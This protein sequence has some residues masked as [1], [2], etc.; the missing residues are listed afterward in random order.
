LK[1]D[2]IAAERRESWVIGADTVVVIGKVRLGKPATKAEARKML[3]LLSGKRHEVMTGLVVTCQNQNVKV[4][5][6]EKTGVWFKTIG[7]SELEHY[8]S[9]PEPYDKAGS[10]GIQGEAAAFVEKIEGELSNVMGLPL[11][12]LKMMFEKL[13]LL[14]DTI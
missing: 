14:P 11:R 9:T 6:I 4:S 12:R 13:A 3:Q 7:D 5:V 1:A 10:Y 8:I 2:R